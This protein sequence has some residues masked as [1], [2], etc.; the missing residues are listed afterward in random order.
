MGKED[1]SLV[2]DACQNLSV[3][4]STV[5]YSRAANPYFDWLCFLLSSMIAT[6][7]VLT[8]VEEE[9]EPLT[10]SIRY[11]AQ[12]LAELY[13]YRCHKR[14][15]RTGRR[16]KKGST[17]K[18]LEFIDGSKYHKTLMFVKKLL[19]YEIPWTATAGQFFPP[20][21]IDMDVIKELAEI[22]RTGPPST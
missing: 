17:G 11:L 4:A 21:V 13:I 1:F 3:C 2:K 10:S 14:I 7:P 15:Y 6:C 19:S 12:S 8:E 18:I 9:L 22:I 5:S 16:F 20:V